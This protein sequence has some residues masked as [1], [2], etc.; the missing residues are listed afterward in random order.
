MK[1][2]FLL[3]TGGTIASAPGEDGRNVSGALPGEVLVQALQLGPGIALEVQSVFQ[4]PSNA[5]TLDDWVTLGRRCEALISEGLADGIVVTHGTDTLEDTAY[6]LECVLDTARVPVIVTGSQRVPH[7][8]GSDAY[9]NLRRAVEAAAADESRGLGVLVAFNESLYSASFARKVSS[10]RLDGFDAPGLGCLGFVD[11]GRVAILQRPMRQPRLGQVDALPRVD[12]VPVYADASAN[13][14]AAVLASRPAGLVID[15]VGRGHVP[16][17]WMPVLREAIDRG[18]AV[19]VCSSTLHG[20]THQSYEFPGS[21][22]DLEAAGAVGV[23][24]LSARKARIR[25]ALLIANGIRATDSIREA[26]AWQPERC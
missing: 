18:L 3:S 23:S 26:F 5:I 16:P 14:L 12:L 13:L 9:A 17:S 2:I 25:L 4:K 19:L 10:F 24:H 8:L 20:A 7:A 1:R 11:N 6:Y 15:G 22:H 21:L